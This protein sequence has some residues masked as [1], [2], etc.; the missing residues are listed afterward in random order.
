MNVDWNRR[1]SRQGRQQ[2]VRR[3]PGAA[4]ASLRFAAMTVATRTIAAARAYNCPWNR[5]VSHPDIQ[6]LPAWG[7]WVMLPQH[8][9][10]DQALADSRTVHGWFQM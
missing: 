3:T 4:K 5:H 10:K 9:S 7:W 8:S 1:V 6:L 2:I